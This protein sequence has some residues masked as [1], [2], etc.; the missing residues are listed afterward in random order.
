MPPNHPITNF[1]ALL[2][3]GE[4]EVLCAAVNL[5]NDSTI[6]RDPCNEVQ[7]FHLMFD[8][9][10]V[11]F[12]EGAASE[13]F[14]VGEYLCGDNTA[15]LNELEELFPGISKS[16]AQKTPARRI[17]RGFEALALAS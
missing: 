14:L 9:H 5:L 1:R 4:D 12:A 11:I 2:F 17:A 6:L 10:E 13:S 3:F 16:T 15:L 8:A 7:Y